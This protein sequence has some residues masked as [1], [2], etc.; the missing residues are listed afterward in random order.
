FWSCSSILRARLLSCPESP[1][2]W[3]GGAAATP[4]ARRRAEASSGVRSARRR[5]ARGV[6]L[7]RVSIVKASGVCVRG[8][9]N[10]GRAGGGR[11]RRR[12]REEGRRRAAASAARGAGRPAAW[13]SCACPSS[14]RPVCAL[15][16]ARTRGERNGAGG[17][18]LDQPA[19]TAPLTYHGT[20]TLVSQGFFAGARA[21]ALLA[22]GRF[23]E[24]VG[25]QAPVVVLEAEAPVPGFGRGLVV[26]DL[27]VER[28]H[29]EL[30][31]GVFRQRDGLAG[32][33]VTAQAG[34]DVELVDERVA[35]VVLEAVAER[36]DDVAGSGAVVVEEQ[37]DPSEGGLAEDAG[38]RVAG[39]F[40]DE[41]VAVL[42]VVRLHERQDRVEVRG[43][44]EAEGGHRAP[45]RGPASATRRS[46]RSTS[47][48]ADQVSS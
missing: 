18:G 47:S 12:T 27:E 2:A 31:A 37:P 43:A 45:Q 10:A 13:S 4:N 30:A 35:A 32:E 21:R 40:R 11:R 5:A 1:C 16:V 29:A 48:S 15:L 33:A 44:R 6:V 20:G 23:L 41:G 34:C 46:L 24:P 28:A 3:S 8:R 36:E 19:P 14:R 7:V 22:V 25:Q 9:S 17:V 42:G 38:E 39:A 26:F